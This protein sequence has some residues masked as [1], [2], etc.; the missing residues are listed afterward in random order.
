MKKTILFVLTL[1]ISSFS[2]GQNKEISERLT[3]I[4]K[5][6]I[7]GDM[8]I[9]LVNDSNPRFEAKIPNSQVGNFS[10]S[11]ENGDKLVL[12]L[13]YPISTSIE[14]GNKGD[15][16]SL[17]VTIYLPELV[18]IELKKN[19]TLISEDTFKSKLMSIRVSRNSLISMPIDCYD[20][21]INSSTNAILNLTGECVFLVADCSMNSMANLQ[22][23]ECQSVVVNCATNAVC[24]VVAEKKMILK[25]NTNSKIYYKKSGAIITKSATTLG[26]ISEFE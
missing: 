26:K 11:I 6:Y 20:L 9:N 4:S 5:I 21:T 3:D 17:E 25:A 13:K 15:T 2:Y 23:L 24:Y 14:E 16:T 1:L 19:V 8:I 10:W 7:E 22:E 12:E 18:E